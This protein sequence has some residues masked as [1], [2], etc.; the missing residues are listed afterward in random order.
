[1]PILQSA[2]TGIFD[3]CEISALPVRHIVSTVLMRRMGWSIFTSWIIEKITVIRKSQL[4]NNPNIRIANLCGLQ[5]D[6]SNLFKIE[7][8]YA[9]LQSDNRGALCRVLT[10]A[11]SYPIA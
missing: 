7:D 9:H 6:S 5:V 8:S 1:M 3:F 10:G 11:Y 2:Y 4:P